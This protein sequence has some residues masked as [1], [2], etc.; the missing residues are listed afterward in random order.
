MSDEDGRI[1][2]G[3]PGPTDP[4]ERAWA[5]GLRLDGDHYANV[6]PIDWSDDG[7]PED[8]CPAEGQP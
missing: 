5:T 6:K 3:M 4:A 2:W 8:G 7:I 1:P